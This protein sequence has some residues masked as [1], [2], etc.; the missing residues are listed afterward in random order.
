MLTEKVPK[1]LPKKTKKFN[2]HK[3]FHGNSCFAALCCEVTFLHIR[4]NLLGHFLKMDKEIVCPKSKNA[5]TSFFT[6]FYVGRKS[7][8]FYYN[9]FKKTAFYTFE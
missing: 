2:S 4:K 7:G 8:T 6:V 3:Y 9:C 5:P 1:V